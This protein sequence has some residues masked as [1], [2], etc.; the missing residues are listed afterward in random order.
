MLTTTNRK[1]KMMTKIGATK[2]LSFFKSTGPFQATIQQIAPAI[3]ERMNM[4]TPVVMFVP[5]NPSTILPTAF[6]TIIQRITSQAITNMDI[7]IRNTFV[8]L[9]PRMPRTDVYA[10]TPYFPDITCVASDISNT[11]TMLPAIEPTSAVGTSTYSARLPP[12]I[13]HH[14]A[15]A[16]PVITTV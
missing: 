13:K 2:L 1:I 15:H 5:V 4:G 16:K 14:A 12:V 7:K 11:A 10:S 6:A 8:P 3:T 9:P